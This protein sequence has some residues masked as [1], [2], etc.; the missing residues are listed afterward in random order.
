MPVRFIYLFI[1]RLVPVQKKKAAWIEADARI[2]HLYHILSSKMFIGKSTNEGNGWFPDV[3]WRN[4][5]N[6]DLVR[7]RRK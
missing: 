7:D 5:T 1:D 3:T 2:R 4:I 6:Y